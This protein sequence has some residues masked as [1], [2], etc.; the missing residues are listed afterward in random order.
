MK[1]VI[2][3]MYGVILKDPD[4]GFIPFVTQ[5]FANVT[6]TEIYQYWDKVDVGEMSTFDLFRELEYRGDFGKIEK[7][8]LDTV[9]I[10]ETF[11]KFASTIKE[12]Y[13]F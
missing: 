6:R 4:G 1:A 9:E 12:Y 5:T 10:N 8:Y 2:L 13:K 11:Y 7:D 3:D